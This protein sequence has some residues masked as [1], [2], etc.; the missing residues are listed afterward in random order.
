MLRRLTRRETTSALSKLYNL[1]SHPII[2]KTYPNPRPWELESLFHF[3]VSVLYYSHI[4]GNG[5]SHGQAFDAIRRWLRGIYEPMAAELLP[6]LEKT[7]KENK[8]VA[9]DR[10]IEKFAEKWEEI[11]EDDHA[12]QWHHFSTVTNSCLAECILL[13]NGTVER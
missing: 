5:L 6:I 13:C 10:Y 4:S 9:E 11:N 1:P 12:V 8:L 7:R 3:A 2:L